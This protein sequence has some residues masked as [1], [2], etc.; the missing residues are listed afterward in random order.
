MYL[1]APVG[2]WSILEYACMV[3]VYYGLRGGAKGE[4]SHFMG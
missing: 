4:G 3:R 1:P 2:Q